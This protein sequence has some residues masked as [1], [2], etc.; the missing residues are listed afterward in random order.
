[1]NHFL[2]IIWKIIS[3]FFLNKWFK[4]FFKRLNYSNFKKNAF[5]KGKNNWANPGI[6]PG[7]H[8]PEAC[9]LPVD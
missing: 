7:S 9:I 3:F 8:A 2:M 1:M 4:I 6:E 5:L